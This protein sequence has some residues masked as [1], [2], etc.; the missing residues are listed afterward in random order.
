MGQALIN[1]WEEKCQR[2]T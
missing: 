1:C 2:I